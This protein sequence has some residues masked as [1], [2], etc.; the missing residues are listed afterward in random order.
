VSRSGRLGAATEVRIWLLPFSSFDSFIR[1]ST[2]LCRYRRLVIAPEI[3]RKDQ[4][5]SSVY[6]QLPFSLSTVTVIS[7]PHRREPIKGVRDGS[8]QEAFQYPRFL[9]PH[10][11]DRRLCFQH[12]HVDSDRRASAVLI[13]RL[14]FSSPA[15][16]RP[17]F[18]ASFPIFLFCARRRLHP[19]TRVNAAASC[20]A[21]PVV[22]SG[23]TPSARPRYSTLFSCHRERDT[24]L[25]YTFPVFLA[26]SVRIRAAFEARLP[27]AL[28]PTLW[29]DREDMPTAMR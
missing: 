27:G 23:R 18:S 17:V 3:P 24:F 21:R 25:A 20:W 22:Q 6:S 26:S 11:V 29:S 1:E 4:S 9:R 8:A 7:V 15:R 5:C 14:A 13:Y 19:P 16:A 2:S 10:A 12:W 28:I